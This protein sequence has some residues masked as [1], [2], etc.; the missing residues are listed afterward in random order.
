VWQASKTPKEALDSAVEQSNLLLKDFE[1][2]LRTTPLASQT[3]SQTASQ[4]TQQ[5]AQ[6]SAPAAPARPLK[7]TKK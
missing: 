3:A 7:R 1:Q 6:E 4:S 5:P 2:R